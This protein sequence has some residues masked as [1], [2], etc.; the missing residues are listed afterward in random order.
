MRNQVSYDPRSCECN[1]CNCVYRSLKTSGLR[2]CG[3]TNKKIKDF[4]KL[5]K[6][7]FL[8]HVPQCGFPDG[9]H[10]ENQITFVG[11]TGFPVRTQA[12]SFPLEWLTNSK[13]SR[14]QT[15]YLRQF[16]EFVAHFSTVY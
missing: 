15:F 4:S 10:Q 8:C 9:F 14:V 12:L 13:E 11:C 6:I 1:L 7:F 16:N 3:K 5:M 2:S